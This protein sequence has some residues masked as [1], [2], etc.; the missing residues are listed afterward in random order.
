MGLKGLIPEKGGN[1]D[2][3]S[4]LVCV[5]LP[6][7]SSEND[8]QVYMLYAFNYVHL[9]GMLYVVVDTQFA[10]IQNIYLNYLI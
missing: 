6:S 10:V 7:S 9:L 3:Q 5:P 1:L 4:F 2:I 8:K